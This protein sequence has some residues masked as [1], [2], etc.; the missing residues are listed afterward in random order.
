[1]GVFGNGCV[2]YDLTVPGIKTAICRNTTSDHMGAVEPPTL[3][4]E[5]MGADKYY[6]ASSKERFKLSVSVVS[7]FQPLIKIS[8]QN[9][10]DLWTTLC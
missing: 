5:R 3:L 8:S 10:T 6:L 1:M 7:Y 4:Y 9:I 2:D